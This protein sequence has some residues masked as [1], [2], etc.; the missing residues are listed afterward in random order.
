MAYC[1]QCKHYIP[2]QEISAQEVACPK[3][4]TL[5]RF[6]KKEYNAVVR[7]GIY[8]VGLFVINFFWTKD[9]AMRLSIDVAI[10]IVW[11]AFYIRFRNYLKQTCLEKFS[12]ESS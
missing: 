7:P 4:L 6:N 3:C 9:P 11:F 2:P 12:Y 1:C 8:V 5:L 10:I